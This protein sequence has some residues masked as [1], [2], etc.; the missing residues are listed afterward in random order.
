MPLSVWTQ[1]SGFKFTN[2]GQPFT[3]GVSVD[4]TLPLGGNLS[5][6]NLKIISGDLPSGLFLIGTHIIGSPFIKKN[7]TDYS[8]CIRA[9]KAGEISDRTYNLSLTEPNVPTFITNPGDLDI[10]LAQQYYVLDGSYVNYQ[11][12]S[13][14]LA[15][16]R[17]PVSYFIS[18]GDGAL[19]PGLSLSKDGVISGYIIPVLTILP[20]DGNGTYD[21]SIYDAVAFDFGL[22][23]SN[24]FDNYTY[25]DVFFDFAV[26]TQ[27]VVSL[28]ANYQFRVT[29]TDGV[30]STQ[31]LFR[32]FVVGNGQFRADNTA[33]TGLA[34]SFTADATYIRQ[35]VWI[36]N[37]DLGLF[38]A[39]NYLTIP[40]ALYDENTVSFRVETTNQEIYATSI[41][42]TSQDNIVGSHS[43]TIQNT[44]AVPVVGQ[45]FDLLHYVPGATGEVYQIS[46]VTSLG[47]NR[48]R[49]TIYNSLV[50]TIPNTSVIYIGSLSKLPQGTKFDEQT[51]DVFGVVP[52]Q[53]AI[54]KNYKF[55]ITSTRY[56][57]KTDSV[58]ASKTFSINILGDITSEI[59]WITDS[60][61]GELPANYTSTLN[62]T[63]YSNVT[64][65][66]VIYQLTGGTLPPGLALNPDGELIGKVNQYYKPATQ[67]AGLITFDGGTTTFDNNTTSIERI[68]TFK[69]TASD[70]Y[71]Y[72]ATEKEFSILVTTPNTVLYSNITTRPFLNS[73]QRTLWRNFINNTNV[74]TPTSI[75]RTNDPVFGIQSSLSMLVYAGIETTDAAAYIGA[76][77]LNHKRK[78]FQF[79]SVKK[80]LA[81]D[82]NTKDTLYEVVY[83][84][85]IDPLEPD[86]KFLPSRIETVTDKRTITIDTSNSIW[87]RSLSDLNADGLNAQ[88]PE[89]NITADSTGYEASNPNVDTYFPSSITNWQKRLKE[90]GLSERN[91]LP[92][93][94]RSIP[95]GS[96]KQLGYTLAVPLCFCKPGT[97]DTILLNIKF[98]GFDFK[99]I[100]YTVDR[101]IIDS[102]TGQDSDKYLVFRND[103]ITV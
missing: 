81:I 96:K 8:F 74:F 62:V 24:G 22:R 103:R 56:G 26:P 60:N 97:A 92:L 12:E 25:D 31:R 55:T 6:V 66:V 77:G 32:I 4:L 84:E 48:Y 100:D 7:R 50:V 29:I 99:S 82:P 54:T 16:D 33:T 23:P 73:T 41:Q 98:S 46:A 9:S 38:R 30:T 37:S 43:V 52:Y 35:P 83:V 71:G 53:P 2:N 101:Y 76:M 45:Y 10:G 72:T 70:Q 17:Q 88:R 40:L 44:T 86:K 63:A 47:N 36:S 51:G 90:V 93:W 67:A 78:R 102:V 65:S 13:I 79:G 11:L 18:S 42:I 19:P 64:G 5:G 27:Q 91:Y 20:N 59:V 15:D 34:S 39:N 94:M 69:I 58:S 28:N 75:Y 68:F 1:P 80:A 57:D 87:S 21:A 61:L 89:Q 95:Q 85:M 14:N 49:L 3:A